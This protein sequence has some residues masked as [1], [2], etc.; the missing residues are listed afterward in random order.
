MKL[1]WILAPVCG[2][3]VLVAWGML[4]WGLLAGPLGTFHKL[5]N[6]RAVTDT[7]SGGGTPTGTYFMPWPRR[8]T[9]EIAA[10]EAQHKTE[11][12]RASCRERV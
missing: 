8:T 5:P 12:G 10:F 11:I 7:L 3:V 6:D 1:R 4:F 2:M 9:E